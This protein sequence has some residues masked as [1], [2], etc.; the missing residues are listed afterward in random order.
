MRRQRQPCTQ[1]QSL[2]AT[3]KR[4]QENGAYIAE[5]ELKDTLVRQD[6]G[7]VARQRVNDGQAVNALL[8]QHPQS[9]VE[10][11]HGVDAHKVLWPLALGQVL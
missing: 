11:G 1:R 9:A 4:S 3:K 10:V 6:G 2:T 5:N 7:G 8:Q